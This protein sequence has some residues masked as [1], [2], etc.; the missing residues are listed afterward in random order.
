[1]ALSRRNF[2]RTA[3][4]ASLAW[5]GLRIFA[6]EPALG[7]PGTGQ[8]AGQGSAPASEFIY[9]TQ[10]YRPPNPPRA[11]RRRML[12]DVA[13][14]YGFNIIRIYPMWDYYNREPGKFDFSEIDEVMKYA[15]EFGLRVLMGIVFETAPY[16][17]EQANPEA[18]FVDA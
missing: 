8:E 18:R 12:K 15:D 14:K 16:W 7:E 3:A 9:G 6:G 13:Q 5:G 17:L 4:G 11:E 10:F 1:M 2:I